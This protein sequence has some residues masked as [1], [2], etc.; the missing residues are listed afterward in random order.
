MLVALQVRPHI[1]IVDAHP[2]DGVEDGPEEPTN[3]FEKA[4]FDT[5]K[6]DENLPLPTP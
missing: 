3:Q 1:Q 4:S 5:S 2:I 6:V